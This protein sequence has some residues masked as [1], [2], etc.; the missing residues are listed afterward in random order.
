LMDIFAILLP[1]ALATFLIMDAVGST[2][3]GS[4]FG[5]LQGAEGWAAF[6]IASYLS[7]HV[8]F[9]LGAW[10][11]EVYD[12]LRRQ[13]L[14]E[15]IA[16][17]ARRGRLLPWPARALV[18]IIFKRERDVAVDRAGQLKRRSL[19]SIDA[20]KAVN[21]FQWS[22]ALL[23]LESPAS[24][25]VVQR[26]EADSKFFRSFAV[27]LLAL[28]VTWPF[29]QLHQRW[30]PW[31]I[32]VV[33]ALLLLAILRYMEQRYKA[34]NQAYW[35]VIT[36]IAR[37]GTVSIEKAP[38]ADGAPTHA[39][40]VVF[41]R[42]RGILEFLLVEATNKPSEWVLPKGHIEPPEDKRETA[43]REVHEE[44][45]VWARILV[46]LDD[47]ISY[48]VDGRRITVQFYLMESV[49]RGLRIDRD[50]RHVWLPGNEAGVKASHPET[51]TLLRSAEQRLTEQRL[52]EAG[53]A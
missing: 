42:R 32:A 37:T 39:G 50:R 47:P 3:L 16:Q 30:R 7:G 6:L 8:I 15:Q 45:G 27:L 5:S 20:A 14:N 4:R 1:G 18:W 43:V 19:G 35:S 33:I 12:R 17:L 11:D 49:A 38:I 23:A 34:T 29:H 52:T 13:T 41:R 9:L 26:F 40:G 36:L 24:L 28:A 53:G 44:A 46:A 31:G 48:T 51:R 25:A 21:T 2:V 10:L 22:K